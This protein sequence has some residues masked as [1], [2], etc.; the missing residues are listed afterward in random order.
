MKYIIIFIALLFAQDVSAVEISEVYYDPFEESGSEAILLFS[1]TREDIS[2]WTIETDSSV[3]DVTFP[4]GTIIDGYFLVTD[5]NWNEKKDNKSWPDSDHEEP[6]TLKNDNSKVILRNKEGEEVD[7]LR[8]GE[9]EAEDVENG[10][11]LRRVSHTGDIREDFVRSYPVLKSDNENTTH[12]ILTINFIVIERNIS[13][14]DDL[15]MEGYQIMPTPGEDREIVLNIDGV[16][17]TRTI[18]YDTKPGE[19]TLEDVVYE[20]MPV[21][22]IDVDIRVINTSDVLI[23]GPSVRNIGNVPLDIGIKVLE[24]GKQIEY[25]FDGIFNEITSEFS[26]VNLNLY[27]SEING[28]T[29]RLERPDVSVSRNILFVGRES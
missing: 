10:Y 22:A 4:D 6:M 13:M 27:P 18:S 15:P 21:L 17:F 23:T 11:S 19:Y 24:E 8:W 28:I 3:R 16:T 12:Q 1:E 2:Q 7:S 20:I 5:Q 26:F 14:T 25:S 29:L 9:N